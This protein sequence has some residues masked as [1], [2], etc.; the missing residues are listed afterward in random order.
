MGGCGARPTSL[1]CG[2]ATP[3]VGVAPELNCVISLLISRL[4][5]RSTYSFVCFGGQNL[6]CHVQLG[7]ALT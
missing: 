1:S 5:M 7:V 6:P 3:P 4:L 2:G